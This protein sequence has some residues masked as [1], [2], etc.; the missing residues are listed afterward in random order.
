MFNQK[1]FCKNGRLILDETYSGNNILGKDFSHHLQITW[2]NNRYM[3]ISRTLLFPNFD[4]RKA[5]Y[6]S[7]N[8]KPG[9]FIIRTTLNLFGNKTLSTLLFEK[10]IDDEF[11]D[12][13]KEKDEK[14]IR[15]RHLVRLH[16]NRSQLEIHLRRLK[17]PT[18]SL[19]L[20]FLIILKIYTNYNNYC[21]K[22]IL[23]IN[24]THNIDFI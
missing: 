14:R 8:W 19:K 17:R 15:W 20:F 3:Y 21:F 9:F 4:L 11:E 6:K 1:A 7:L 23:K 12:W 13:N 5:L 18:G 10:W 2:I 16:V 22:I 24:T